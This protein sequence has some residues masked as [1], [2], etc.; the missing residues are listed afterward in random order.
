M[1][2]WN[3]S[4]KDKVIPPATVTMDKAST[5][6]GGGEPRDI[7]RAYEFKEVLGTYV[8]FG[9]FYSASIRRIC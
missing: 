1:P 3:S 9:L 6:D 4:T 5:S 8:Y 2:L 7:K